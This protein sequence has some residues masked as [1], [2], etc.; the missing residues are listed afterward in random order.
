MATGAA[1]NCLPDCFRKHESKVEATLKYI[2]NGFLLYN[3]LILVLPS[4]PQRHRIFTNVGWR[5]LV[6]YSRFMLKV[7]RLYK[8][9][10]NGLQIVC[11]V[12]PLRA[13]SGRLAK[14]TY[15]WE[16]WDTF[17][18]RLIPGN[19]IR[20]IYLGLNASITQKSSCKVAACSQAGTKSIV[21]HALRFQHIL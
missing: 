16:S 7:A 17:K 14:S 1:L 3:L 21:Q 18:G 8:L 2:Y 4:F 12:E 6:I 20:W 10:L 5:V 15:Q 13:P 9:F 11:S 19:G